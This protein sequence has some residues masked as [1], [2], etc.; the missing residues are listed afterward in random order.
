M[1]IRQLETEEEFTSAARLAYE[2]YVEE[3]GI[4]GDIADHQ[5]RLLH[6]DVGDGARVIGAFE[7]GT[8]VGTIS[9]L[10][11]TD[12]QFPDMYNELF[13]IERFAAVAPRENM[14][15]A[16]SLMLQPG[17]RGAAVMQLMVAT[18]QILAKLNT[19]LLFGDC[20]PHLFR[21][22]TALGLR[23]FGR[24]F[25]YGG[26]GIGIPLVGTPADHEYLRQIKSLG[27][28]LL[29]PQS[30]DRELAAR[31][32][33]VLADNNPVLT[34]Q[35]DNRAY[36][37]A[38]GNL[39]QVRPANGMNPF[40]G[41]SV[42]ELRPSLERGAIITC[43]RGNKLIGR[44][45]ATRTV[46]V[47]VDGELEARIGDRRNAIGPGQMC[48]ELAFLLDSRRT[49]D[50][51]VVSETA[52]VLCLSEKTMRSLSNDDPAVATR[53]LG[54]LARIPAQRLAQLTP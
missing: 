41:L 43:H 19:Q 10:A 1:R 8:L 29:S 6:H 26:S 27:L 47:V 50:V 23:S 28:A 33:A 48:G 36:W 3:C 12:G 21:S 4:L 44:G 17:R 37:E 39:V 46:Y 45:Q 15:I 54:N 5:A 32:A 2:V 20:Q 35:S 25:D 9:L 30:E 38:I 11:G 49:A 51:H 52:R 7:N 40:S 53:F 22:Y 16:T 14:A 31:L 24:V 13:Q 18:W 34:S 42:D